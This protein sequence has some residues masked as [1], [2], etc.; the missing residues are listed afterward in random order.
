MT[1]VLGMVAGDQSLRKSLIAKGRKQLK[2][3]S[4]Q[5]TAK[6]TVKVYQNLFDEK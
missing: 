3:Y 4:W 6:K 1:K 5:K 2:K